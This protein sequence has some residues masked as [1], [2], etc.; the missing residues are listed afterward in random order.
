LGGLYEFRA[1]CFEIR[2]KRVAFKFLGILPIEVSSESRK[3]TGAR[4]GRAMEISPISGIRAMPVVKVPPADSDLTR[5][6]DVEDS[7]RPGDDNY[8]G[9]GGKAAGGQD[10]ETDEPEGGVEA[11]AAAHPTQDGRGAQV[12]FFA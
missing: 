4:K 12:N 9:S 6:L 8:S 5:V 11:E 10:D 7:F 1:V 2:Q 3:R